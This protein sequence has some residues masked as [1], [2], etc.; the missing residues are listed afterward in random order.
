M[1]RERRRK[2]RDLGPEMAERDQRQRRVER[3]HLARDQVVLH[4]GSTRLR[5]N[6]N[7][8]SG[9]IAACAAS[10]SARNAA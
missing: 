2:A 6:S 9:S 4:I 5:M 7:A 10:G 3:V 8:P 1:Q